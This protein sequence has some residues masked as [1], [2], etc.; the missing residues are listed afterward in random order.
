[1]PDPATQQRHQWWDGACLGD[2]DPVRIMSG[3][4]A[5]RMS[6][7]FCRLGRTCG[8][9]SRTCRPEPTRQQHHQ[10][11]DGTR[12]GDGDSVRSIA[13]HGNGTVCH[14]AGQRGSRVCRRLRA[15]SST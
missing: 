5:E 4:D 2:S 3:Q 8:R 14:Q 13:L 10:R 6:R 11:R 9:I 1:M 15:G 7:M 12:L